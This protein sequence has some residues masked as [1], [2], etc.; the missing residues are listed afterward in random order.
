M[1]DRCAP[2][3]VEVGWC[4]RH[5]RRRPL[6]RLDVP[7]AWTEPDGHGRHPSEAHARDTWPVSRGWTS[8]LTLRCHFDDGTG[9]GCGQLVF[10]CFRAHLRWADRDAHAY[11]RTEPP[12]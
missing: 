3:L 4:R 5:D 2:G 12:G 1:V 10:S 7:D 6:A 11:R 8:L 9:L